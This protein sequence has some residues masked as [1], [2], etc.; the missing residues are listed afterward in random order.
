MAKLL[1]C[2]GSTT[3]RRRGWHLL[4]CLGVTVLS[5]APVLGQAGP[6]SESPPQAE[7][8]WHQAEALFPIRVLLPEDFDATGTYPAVIALHGYGSSSEKFERIGR[9]FAE[10][11][12]IAALP[13]GPYSFPSDDSVR[14]S[15][16]ELSTWLPE[17]A[18][19]NEDPA[20]E[21]R[22]AMLTIHQFLPTV[23][24]RIEER[25]RVGP[26]YAFG[27]SLGGV[28]ALAGG[29]YNRD[30]FDGIVA[31]GVGYFEEEW[32]TRDG[33]ALEDGNHLPVRLVQGRSDPMVPFSHAERAR[34]L[35]EEAG[36]PVVLDEF[37]GGHTVPDDA[38]RRAVRW[39]VELAARP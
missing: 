19:L 6:A 14:H 24:D 37:A 31:F 10:A 5:S 27:F 34:D 18:S 7:L 3:P 20:I 29:F 2:V 13:E 1:A 32:F 33:G 21:R 38:L 17:M 39:L 4:V 30:R 36:Y 11:G 26:L 15:T 28:Y 12:F 35:L 23:I 25:Y 9:A 16:W 22:S 8:L